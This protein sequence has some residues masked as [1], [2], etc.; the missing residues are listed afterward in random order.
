[1]VAVCE[2]SDDA[3]EET[4]YEVAVIVELS[5][6]RYLSGRHLRYFHPWD[7]YIY[8]IYLAFHVSL[9]VRCT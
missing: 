8:I 1:M 7:I 3:P 4:V 5:A 9:W 6:A 2:G